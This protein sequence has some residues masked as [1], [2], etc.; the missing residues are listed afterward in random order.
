[1]IRRVLVDAKT[2]LTLTS[3]AGGGFAISIV[4]ATAD[5]ARRLPRLRRVKQ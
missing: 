5:D 2:A 3:V 4:E 1:M